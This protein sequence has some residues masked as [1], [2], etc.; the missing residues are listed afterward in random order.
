MILRGAVAGVVTIVGFTGLHHL[1]ISDIWAM[2]PMMAVA[3][4][5]TGASLAWTLER[6]DLAASLVGWFALAAGYLVLLGALGA[7]SLWL[8]TPVTT[9]AAVSEAS[10]PVDELIVRALPLSTAWVV[11]TVGLGAVLDHRRT[12]R[13]ARGVVP[14]TLS[15]VLVLL[16]LGLNMSV[17][18]LV[19]LEGDALVAMARFCGLV[20]LVVVVHAL[21]FAGLHS[22]AEQR[23]P[24]GS[25]GSW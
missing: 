14:L 12:G 7:C 1:L 8:F 19:E 16:T 23:R 5:A 10:G 15:T 9:F 11:V 3:A 18:G 6:L 2:L 21:V 25:P 17:L 4:A 22:V 20:G 24:P 13:G